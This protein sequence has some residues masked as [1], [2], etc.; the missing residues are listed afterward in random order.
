LD[1]VLE[2]IGGKIFS[3][4]FKQMSPGGRIIVYG[5][6]QFS[7]GGSRPNLFKLAIKFFTRPNIDPLSLSDKNKSV[8][9]FNLF[10]L[11]NKIELLKTYL[12][13]ILEM[14]L[15][16]PLIGEVFEFQDLLLAVKKF[17]SGQTMGKVIVKID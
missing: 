9:G 15:P 12:N 10:Y 16:K 4:S 7:T 17:Q 2:C 13:N 3:K 6:A 8:M 1:T 14:N 11:W 5:A